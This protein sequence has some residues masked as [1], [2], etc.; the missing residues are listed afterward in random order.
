MRFSFTLWPF[1]GLRGPTGATVP[2]TA[3]VP[4]HLT[5]AKERRVE[6]PH[7][8]Q[9]QCAMWPPLVRG[10]WRT[11]GSGP[12]HPAAYGK[13]TNEGPVAERTAGRSTGPDGRVRPC[14]SAS[15]LGPMAF[16][17]LIPS[18]PRASAFFPKKRTQGRAAFVS[19]SSIS[20]VM[21]ISRQQKQSL[22]QCPA[23]TGQLNPCAR[24]DP[25]YFD[26]RTARRTRAIGSDRASKKARNDR[27][28]QRH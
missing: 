5:D 16:Q 10:P 24:G 15:S 4:G 23:F 1:S 27:L 3:Q 13:T 11:R 7:V 9:P 6:E 28:R 20:L 25:G 22:R 17:C 12:S 21:K 19:T 14:R 26:I 2:A 18:R 8:D